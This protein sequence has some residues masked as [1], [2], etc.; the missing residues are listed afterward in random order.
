MDYDPDELYD[1]IV[2][3]H[4]YLKDGGC[5]IDER[6]IK[7]DHSAGYTGYGD[8]T[9]TICIGSGFLMGRYASTGQLWTVLPDGTQEEYTFPYKYKP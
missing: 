3:Y 4:R 2:Q 7:L 8:Y 1:M 9:V 6:I 5:P